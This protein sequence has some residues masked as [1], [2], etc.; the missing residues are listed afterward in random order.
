M[1]RMSEGIAVAGQIDD[2]TA[3]IETR[4]SDAVAIRQ[5]RKARHA[6]RIARVER[7]RRRGT[8]PVDRTAIACFVEGRDRSAHVRREQ[9]APGAVTQ[10]DE[11]IRRRGAQYA[12]CR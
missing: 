7:G 12:N 11:R 10:L 9:Y 2:R 4:I 3:E 5:E 1:K 6:E 8:Q